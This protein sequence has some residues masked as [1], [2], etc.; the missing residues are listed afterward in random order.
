[1]VGVR[2]SNSSDSRR[3]RDVGVGVDVEVDSGDCDL[4]QGEWVWDEHYPLY[5][6]RDCAFLDEGF[7]CSENGRP[8]RFYTKWRWQPSR[9]KLPR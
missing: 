5:D 3:I 2:S 7:R 9:C 4:F 1:M 8:D 6:S